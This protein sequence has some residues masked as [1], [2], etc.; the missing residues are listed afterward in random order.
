M[1]DKRNFLW[2]FFQKLLV[3]SNTFK[4]E[5]IPPRLDMKQKLLRLHDEIQV[6]KDILFVHLCLQILLINDRKLDLNRVLKVPHDQY[7]L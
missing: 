2:F 4:I 3:E 5:D 6:C 7:R 1:F